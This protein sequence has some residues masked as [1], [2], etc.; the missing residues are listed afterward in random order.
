MH[1]F[2][3]WSKWSEPF[4]VSGEDFGSPITGIRDKGTP[5]SFIAQKKICEVCGIFKQRKV[6]QT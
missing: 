1:L 6:S 4:I 5:F 2:H 3:K